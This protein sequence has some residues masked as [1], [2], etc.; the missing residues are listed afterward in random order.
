MRASTGDFVLPVDKPVGP[1]SHD[2]VARTRRALSTRRVGHTGTLDPFASGLML[3]CIGH[4]TRIAEYLTGVDKEY[5]ATA[6][7]GIETDTLDREGEVVGQ[8][9]GV[10]AID[11]DAI[12]AALDAQRGAL[13]QV[14]PQFSAKK[15]D[16]EAMHRR[17]RRGEIVE[18]PPVRVH[19]REV[20]VLSF[21]APFVRFRVSCSSGTYIRA[22]ARDLGASLGVGAHLTELRRTRVGS[23]TVDA[24]LSIDALDDAAGVAE[25][26]IEPAD[27]LHFPRLSLDGEAARRLRHGQRIRVADEESSTSTVERVAACLED[28]LVAIAD[29]DAGVLRPRKVF[30]T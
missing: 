4:A 24:A 10:D 28:D 21:D 18:L 20:E 5:V 25:A 26:R 12:H 13:D 2:V 30:A 1:T 29:L 14:P 6:R 22:I 16:G 9:D 8:S 7:L 3:L 19:V 15:V 27:A 23:A 11:P 17:A